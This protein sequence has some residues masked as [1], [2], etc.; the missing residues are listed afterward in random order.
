MQFTWSNIYIV[1]VI[2]NDIKTREVYK[3]KLDVI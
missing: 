1:I 2:Q 3:V